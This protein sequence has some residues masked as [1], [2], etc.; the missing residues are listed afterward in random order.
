MYGD[1][2]TLSGLPGHLIDTTVLALET[3]WEVTN[4]GELYW[5]LGIQITLNCDSIDHSHEAFVDKI[6]KWFQMYKS[7]LRLLPIDP[8]TR[9]TK[10]N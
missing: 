2:L 3:E 1:D 6:L 10:E 4:M 9:L 7:H 5:L 8:N